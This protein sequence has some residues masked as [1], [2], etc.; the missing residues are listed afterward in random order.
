MGSSRKDESKDVT[1][2]YTVEQ[3]GAYRHTSSNESCSM[4]SCQSGHP[5]SPGPDAP[6]FKNQRFEIIFILMNDHSRLEKSRSQRI[7]WLLEELKV[8]YSLKT[9]KRQKNMLAPPELT[10]IHPLG[11]SPIIAVSSNA[12]NGTPL[13][14]A[15]SSN[16]IEYLITHFGKH[17][18]P[19]QWQQGKEGEVG[20]ETEEW[21]RYRYLMHYAEGTLMPYLVTMILMKSM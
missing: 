7:L 19:Q 12:T 15:E 17:L 2:Y 18:Q 8:P 13:I 14:I 6:S 3:D 10:K 21:L 9:F 11:K 20:G 1:V 5:L 16:I 4:Y